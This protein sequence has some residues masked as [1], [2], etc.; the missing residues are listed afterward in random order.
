MKLCTVVRAGQIIDT[1]VVP[2]DHVF[3]EHGDHFH[4]EGSFVDRHACEPATTGI[5]N[6]KLL[7]RSA[8][9]ASH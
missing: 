5:I 3:G 8:E 2:D 4:T 7:T 1:A 6:M 9:R